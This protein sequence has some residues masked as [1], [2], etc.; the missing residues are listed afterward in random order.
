MKENSFIVTVTL[1]FI[2][3]FNVNAV[4]QFVNLVALSL[5]S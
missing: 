1:H 5:L 4:V 3:T 2:M